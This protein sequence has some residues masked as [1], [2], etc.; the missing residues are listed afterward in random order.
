MRS[1]QRSVRTQR[2]CCSL[3]WQGSSGRPVAWTET[4]SES[5]VS[6]GHGRGQVHDVTIGGTG[7]GRVTHY[8]LDI[9]QD[10]V[11]D[12]DRRGTARC[13][14]DAA[15]GLRRVRHRQHRVSIAGGRHQHRSRRRLS[16]RRPARGDGGDRAGDRSV[17]RRARPRSCGDPPD[18]PDPAVQRAAH[19]GDRPGL[20]RR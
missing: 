17:R 14:D 1:G 19:D 3:A 20:R 7:D 2:S 12:G 13:G 9:L 11:L 4:R 5:M 18:Q 10:C 16:R 15:D 8:R 6:L